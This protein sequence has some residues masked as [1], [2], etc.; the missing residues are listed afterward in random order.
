MKTKYDKIF[1]WTVCVLV[2]VGFFMLVSASM[3]LLARDGA[4][5]NKTVFNQ[6]ILGGGV[7]FI[8]LAFCAKINYKIWKKLALPIFV[9]SLILTALVFAP[10]IGFEVGGSHRWI[11]LGPVAFQPS[12]FLKF[13]FIVYLSAWL[14]GR[15]DKISSF[16]Y[17]LLPFLA[18]TAIAGGLLIAEPDIGSLGV[19]AVTSLFLFFLGGGKY[20]QI[21]T[22]FLLGVALIGTLIVLQPYRIDRLKTFLDPSQ[23][24]R[25]ISYQLKQSLIAFGSGGTFGRGFGMSVQKFNYLPEPIG[26]SIFAVFGEEFGFVGCVALI[27]LFLFF[28]FRG[29]LIAK[30]APDS[31]GRLLASGIVI[32]ITVGSFINIV[33]MVGLFPLTGVPL[34]FVSKGGSAMAMALAQ[35]G[36]LLNISKYN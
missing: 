1:F 34:I 16:Q 4:G 24:P 7:G 25:G 27:G 30:R 14:A 12:E 29:L 5:F 13:G 18:I 26:D 23:D 36:I 10:K 15:K 8:A 3:G 33:S 20:S 32:M 6:M 11:T 35:I 2:L 28:L 21:F 19:L 9:F 31:F 17:G 22:I